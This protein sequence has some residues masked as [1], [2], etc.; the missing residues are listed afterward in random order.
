MN[1]LKLDFSLETAEERS[2][3]IKSYIV[4][5]SSLTR[6]EA[7]TIANYLLWG[8]D[9][10]ED[11][12]GASD[13]EL[14]T[15]WTK[16]NPVESL[17]ALLESQI[18]THTQIY[19]LNNAPKLKKPRIVFSRTETRQNCPPYLL[20]SFEELW[21][22]IDQTD[23]EICL[24][25]IETGKRTKPPRPSL[26]SRFTEE[27]IEQIRNKAKLLTPR[28]YLKARHRL[29]DLRREQFSLKDIYSE[30]ISFI[31]EANPEIVKWD[32]VVFDADVEIFPLGLANTKV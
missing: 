13:I 2:E 29:I 23:L 26:L 24:Y 28:E 3:F 20:P 30:K 8:K 4:Q 9:S 15:K 12:P 10:P 21:R 11:S 16:V 14:E 7:E 18:A 1:R 19:Q 17:D 31:Q 6:K 27:E 25:E 32:K 5:F 22:I